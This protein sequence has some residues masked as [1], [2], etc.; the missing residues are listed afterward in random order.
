MLHV[1]D[2]HAPAPNIF[3]SSTTHTK[4]TP[5]QRPDLP[6]VVDT[7]V[8]HLRSSRLGVGSLALDRRLLGLLVVLLQ[9][10]LRR[11][12]VFSLAPGAGVAVLTATLTLTGTAEL[13][14]RVL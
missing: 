5:R 10:P 14:G 9:L 3:T 13:L 6:R 7:R 1:S 8:S 2:H 4:T 11:L 12:G